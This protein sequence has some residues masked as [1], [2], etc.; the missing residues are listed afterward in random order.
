MKRQSGRIKVFVV[1]DPKIDG[2]GWWRN[3]EPFTALDKLHGDV[4][5]IRQETEKVDIRELKTA[6]VVVRFRPITESAFDFLELCKRIGCKIIVDIDDDLWHLPPSH[7]GFSDWMKHRDSVQRIYEIADRVWVS[8]DQLMYVIGDL[9]RCEIMQNAILP[10]QLPEKP[11]EWKSTA[12]WRG[13][14]SQ[15]ADILSEAAREK[16]AEARD[17]YDHW[18]FAGYFPDFPHKENVKLI[19]GVEPL[20]YFL[21]LQKGF[22]NVIWKPLTPNR[23]NDAKSN[24]AWIEATMS[25]GVCVTNYAGRTG[26]E[27]CFD[28]FPTDPQLIAQTWAISA[29]VIRKNFNLYEVT[30]R[31]FRSIV[32]LI[33]G[34][35][36]ERPSTSEMQVKI[37]SSR[38]LEWVEKAK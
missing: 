31:R 15:V 33:N 23:F 5:E 36:P 16:Y 26:W 1:D 38:L 9:D 20:A 4:L 29:D 17:K 19:P 25:G 24:I 35:Q 27:C 37:D 22:A 30:E 3:S 8:T 28:D 21:S 13:N 18:I 32:E 10:E 14:S 12:A 11:M 6:D 2:V 34:R 7:P